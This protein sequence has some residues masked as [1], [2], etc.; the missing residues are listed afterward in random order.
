[1]YKKYT[2]LFVDDEVN[3]LRT[4]CRIFA[5]ENY[6]LLTAENAME[7]TKILE[8]KVVDLIISDQR[9]PGMSG[10]DFFE[11]TLP[12]Y[13]NIIR[14]ILTGQADLEMA[15]EAINK[16]CVYKFILKPWNN[17]DLLFTVKRALEQYDLIQENNS[18]TNELKKRDA[19]LQQLEKQHPGI[20]RMPDGP[21]RIS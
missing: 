21:Y 6:E 15:I 9:M 13:P 20:T 7:A 1:M 12:E 19:I 5:D 10:L 14:I 3:I 4:L 16:G 18:L 8:Q 17:H 2:V 11:K